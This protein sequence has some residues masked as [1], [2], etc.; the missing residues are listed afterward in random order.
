LLS[1]EE[2]QVTLM[3]R[4]AVEDS[5]I[6]I[7][8]SD[9]DKLFKPFTQAQRM[10][11]GT[12]LGLFSLKSRINALRGFCGVEDRL[13]GGPGTR[14]WF[15]IPYRPDP[16]ASAAE[17]TSVPDDRKR[18]NEDSVSV[19]DGDPT[20]HLSEKVSSIDPLRIL[21]VDDTLTILKV[22]CRNLRAKGHSVE[23]AENGSQCLERLKA[24]FGMEEIDVV[25]TDLQMP[26]MDGLE[27]VRRYREF[28]AE[29]QLKL[30]EEPAKVHHARA[31]ATA[32]AGVINGT[33]ILSRL[34][35]IGMSANSDAET[36]KEAVKAGMDAFIGKPFNYKEFE[37]A[38]L[39]AKAAVAAGRP[40]MV[41][42]SQKKEEIY[43]Q[44]RQSSEFMASA[45][46]L[47]RAG[48]IISAWDN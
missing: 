24:A 12:G 7:K 35:I 8:E 18:D 38:V 4:V 9:R 14:F 42:S 16:D 37:R 6:G 10:A 30:L 43:R 26:V 23:V 19:I 1:F 17:S 5:G 41:F 31:R 46:A 47:R 29:E 48:H 20:S 44:I 27:C 25:L 13:D 45:S 2:E 11:G 36:A 28:E 15:T 34:I 40:F 33:R 32:G 22:T 39:C 21:L 3:L